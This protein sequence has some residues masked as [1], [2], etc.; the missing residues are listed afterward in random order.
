MRAQE[1]PWRH[2]VRLA[3]PILGD[4]VALLSKELVL[5]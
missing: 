5:A 2:E 4:L 1:E 3:D